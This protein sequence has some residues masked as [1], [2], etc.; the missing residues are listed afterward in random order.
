MLYATTGLGR[1]QDDPQPMR[2]RIAG[3]FG[4]Q[5]GGRTWRYLWTGSEPR[6]TRPDVHRPAGAARVD[7]RVR[8]ERVLESSRPGRRSVVALP[9]RGRRRLL[10][11]AGRRRALA[12][13]REHS[14][15]LGRRRTAPGCVLVGTDTGRAV[16]GHSRGE[17]DAAAARPADGVVR[18]RARMSKPPAFTAEQVA[19]LQAAL[20]HVWSRMARLQ[21]DLNDNAGNVA[22]LLSLLVERGILTPEQFESAVEELTAT[23]RPRVRHAQSQQSRGSPTPASAPIS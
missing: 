17:V 20:E 2:E 22:T 21:G 12:V 5:D 7:R 18:A 14:L 15:G 4:S 8:A 3:L 19:L 1:F 10:A 9:E 11:R 16:A 23:R 6:Y 13:V